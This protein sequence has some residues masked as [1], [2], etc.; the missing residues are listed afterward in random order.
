MKLSVKRQIFTSMMAELIWRA[1]QI[2]GYAVASN[3][4]KRT[5]TQAQENAASG[6]GIAR[7]VHLSGLAVDLLLYIDGIY[8]R[9]TEVYR[10]MGELWKAI[11]EQHNKA[12]PDQTVTAC[13]GGDF[14]V[15]KDGN[16]F[17]L[18]HGGIR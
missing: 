1:N 14:E 13:W 15:K 6:A 10:K 16:H 7:S 4:V 5:Q 11:G 12:H 2:H 8:Q 9:K 3:E 18:E 17:S